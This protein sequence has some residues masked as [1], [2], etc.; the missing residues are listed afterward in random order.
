VSQ[1]ISDLVVTVT[2]ERS[3]VDSWHPSIRVTGRRAG[4]AFLLLLDLH[5]TRA[6]SPEEAVASGNTEAA[7][8]IAQLLE[9]G[10]P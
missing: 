1:D 10:T 6:G 5:E 8:R 4:R 9:K 2:A 7:A 3:G